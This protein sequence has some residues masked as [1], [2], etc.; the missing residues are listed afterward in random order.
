MS[1]EK[2]TTFPKG[3]RPG[4]FRVI[5]PSSDW[6]DREPEPI[7]WLV[8]GAVPRDVVCLFTG[9]SGLGKSLLMQQLQIAAATGNRWVGFEVE[10]CRSFGFYCEDPENILMLR[11]RDICSHFNVDPHD[12]DDVSLVSRIGEQN[13]LVEFDRRTDKPT[14]LPLFEQIRTHV[15][16]FG[17]QL[18]IID[19]AAHTFGGNENYRTQVTFFIS[20]LQKLASEV[21]G[22]VILNA[23]PSV[24]S[25][26]S[27][28]GYSG[29]TA[30]RATVRAHMYLKRPKEYDDEDPSAD[31]DVRILKTAKSN[32]GRSGGVNK[33]AWENGVFVARDPDQVQVSGMMG[34]YEIDKAV[35]DG[36]RYYIARGD[37]IPSGR[38]TKNS[39]DRML[40][41]LPSLRQYR[42]ADIGAAIDRLIE[43]Q[44]VVLVEIGP[45]SRRYKYLRPPDLRYPGEVEELPL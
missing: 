3:R 13:V 24:S 31:H 36:L 19:T 2:V 32:W 35:L 17:A 16:E 6:A 27:G 38:T 12:L 40:S 25:M 4:P 39:A 18:I 29:S 37:L 42:R 45:P 5:Y 22:S 33:V 7:R 26:I 8:R 10:R 1:D 14:V 30:W 11:Q 43:D 34:K 28:S 23:H 21:Q 15:L 41:A 44:K 9:D 20:L